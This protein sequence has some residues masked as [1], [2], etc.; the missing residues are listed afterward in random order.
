M[1][2]SRYTQNYPHPRRVATAPAQVYPTHQAT[3]HAN[4]L[5]CQLQ[6]QC[7]SLFH[8]LPR[9]PRGTGTRCHVGSLLA[10]CCEHLTT[11]CKA[12]GRRCGG[13][14]C[15]IRLWPHTL[16]RFSDGHAIQGAWCPAAPLHWR[17]D[18]T[19][20]DNAYQAHGVAPIYLNQAP[21]EHDTRT[22]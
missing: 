1:Y 17:V 13:C 5:P 10:A 12:T 8:Q 6:A 15:L 3:I 18:S 21:V 20:A 2:L 19:A 14:T 16:P 4:E 7:F 11:Q 22:Q 9:G